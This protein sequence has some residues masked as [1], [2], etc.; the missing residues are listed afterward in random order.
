MPALSIRTENR[1][2][3]KDLRGDL[4][5]V[6]GSL[7]WSGLLSGAERWSSI[8]FPVRLP[9]VFSC[10]L[11]GDSQVRCDSANTPV[12]LAELVGKCLAAEPL[13][14]RIDAGVFG[15]ADWSA[16]TPVVSPKTER[17][18][19]PRPLLERLEW[20]LSIVVRHRGVKTLPIGVRFF[21]GWETRIHQQDVFTVSK[22]LGIRCWPAQI[23]VHARAVAKDIRNHLRK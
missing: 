8:D 5:E 22:F 6:N 1:E 23:V 21:A 2:T 10:R 18:S 12:A 20:L 11:R 3:G 14:A 13:F 16:P 9:V 15:S 19:I 7:R 4:H 17:R